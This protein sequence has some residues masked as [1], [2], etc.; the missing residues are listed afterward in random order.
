[1][2]TTLMKNLEKIKLVYGGNQ[3]RV[4]SGKASVL[5]TYDHL[6][7]VPQGKKEIYAIPMTA[8]MHVKLSQGL[9]GHWID[10]ME[11]LYKETEEV[12]DEPFN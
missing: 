4:Y 7:V 12:G 3:V 10:T 8:N 6:V 5:I 2:E 9:E 1:M 11:A